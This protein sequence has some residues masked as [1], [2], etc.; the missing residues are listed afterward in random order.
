MHIFYNADQNTLQYLQ[1]YFKGSLSEEFQYPVVSDL[2]GLTPGADS[3][4]Y[5]NNWHKIC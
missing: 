2:K 1:A 4:I 5:E 3:F